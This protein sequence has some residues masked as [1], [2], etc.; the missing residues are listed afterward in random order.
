MSEEVNIPLPGTWYYCKKCKHHW[1]VSHKCEVEVVGF[2]RKLYRKV[3]G[4]EN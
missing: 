3:F 4:K 2:W 1:S